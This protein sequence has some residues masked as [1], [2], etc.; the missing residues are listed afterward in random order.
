MAKL[1]NV[2]N[3][4]QSDKQTDFDTQAHRICCCIEPAT[5][6][7]T[8][9]RL[10]LAGGGRGCKCPGDS[11]WRL[12]ALRTAVV[13]HCEWAWAWAWEGAPC[14]LCGA[15]V[16]HDK[17]CLTKF[18]NRWQLQFTGW[19]CRRHL[20]KYRNYNN[21]VQPRQGIS[22]RGGGARTRTRIRPDRHMQRAVTAGTSMSFA[23]RQPQ[24]DANS[25][26]WLKVMQRRFD[27]AFNRAIALQT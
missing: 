13:G 25:I 8:T 12:G 4:S 9:R 6:S 23:C 1:T 15:T 5:Y 7:S 2:D 11:S 22:L 26:K 16:D 24:L 21:D 14:Q 17:R 27:D 19:Q 18:N 3:G 10:V 20:C